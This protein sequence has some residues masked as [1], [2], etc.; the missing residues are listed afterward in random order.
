[1]STLVPQ[2]LHSG[3]VAEEDHLPGLQDGPAKMISNNNVPDILLWLVPGAL[4]KVPYF[5][6]IVHI[7]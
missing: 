3:V 4:F 6:Y 7:I 5:K 1:M 2:G